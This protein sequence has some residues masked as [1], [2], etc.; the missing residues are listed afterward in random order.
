MTQVSWWELRC[1][2]SIPPPGSNF[3]GCGASAAAG[4]LSGRPAPQGAD[5]GTARNT[6]VLFDR[7]VTVVVH[8]VRWPAGIRQLRM[9]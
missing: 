8:G 3:S 6:C 7:A 2:G 5:V 1:R 9:A 4:R